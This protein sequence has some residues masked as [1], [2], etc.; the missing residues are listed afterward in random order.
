MGKSCFSPL[1]ILRSNPASA[2]IPPSRSRDTSPCPVFSQSK[3]VPWPKG[4]PR[5]V[6][7][8]I[9]EAQV[10]TPLYWADTWAQGWRPASASTS[11]CDERA[12]IRRPQ[13]AWLA[14]Q[15]LS[16]PTLDPYGETRAGVQRP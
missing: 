9:F 6:L 1:V 13:T 11:E 4:P 16:S 5:R 14:D 8:L 7:S 2:A 10:C 3:N 12:F 15:S